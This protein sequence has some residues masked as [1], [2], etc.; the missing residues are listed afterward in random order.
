[1]GVRRAADVRHSLPAPSDPFHR[2][3]LESAE[4]SDSV[5][6]VARDAGGSVAET[7]AALGRLEADGYLVRRDLGGWERAGC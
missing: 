5:E 7:R 6:A 1:V 4:G 3:V 2:A